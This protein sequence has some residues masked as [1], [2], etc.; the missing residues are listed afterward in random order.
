MKMEVS[1]QIDGVIEILN[2]IRLGRIAVREVYTEV[3]SPMSLP[4]QW[5]AEAAEMYA[6]SPTTE[7]I[8]QAEYRRGVF[9]QT[10]LRRGY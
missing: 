6:Y 9:F 2:S 10:L 7:G 4:L 3:P 5:Q 1:M 8:R